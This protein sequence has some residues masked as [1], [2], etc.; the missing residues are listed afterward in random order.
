MKSA[1]F[2]V[3]A[4]TSSVFADEVFLR[5]GGHV[6]GIIVERS[7][8]TV[9]LD[10]GAGRVGIPTSHI[11]HIVEGRT[12]LG[13]YLERSSA[14]RSNDEPG[15]L[16]LGLWA[17]ERDLQTQALAAFERVIAID[18][19]NATAERALGRVQQG[20][21]WVTAE[22]NYRSRGYVPFEGSW[23]SPAERQSILATR[24]A[25]AAADASRAEAA[26]RTREAEARARTAEAEAQSAEAQA[27][28]GVEG[29]IPVFWGAFGTPFL[30]Q[31]HD[32]PDH[33]HHHG[34][35]LPGRC[36]DCSP[37]VAPKSPPPRHAPT[38][39]TPPQTGSAQLGP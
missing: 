29:G 28:A 31:H 39:V 17:Q 21:D 38:P 27:G 30:P 7:P 26:A 37:P 3:L 34:S 5:G 15:W 24:A 10:V 13:E 2:A 25:E 35:M 6:K 22:D 4:V 14:L 32:H 9:L 1:L 23:V 20:D 11:D 19:S 12:A 18:P 8:S 33:P 36:V 16:A